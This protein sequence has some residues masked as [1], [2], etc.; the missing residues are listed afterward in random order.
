MYAFCAMIVLVKACMYN[1]C[2]YV[3]MYVSCVSVRT[4]T[5]KRYT[6]LEFENKI[7]RHMNIGLPVQGHC[8]PSKF[9][10][11][12]TKQIRP[13]RFRKSTLVKD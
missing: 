5:N 7:T 6:I 9:F 12:N 13:I 2:M 8:R 11:F 1:V 10:S 4:I 3:C